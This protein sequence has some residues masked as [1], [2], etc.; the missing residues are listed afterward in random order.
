MVGKARGGMV[1][2]AFITGLFGVVVALVHEHTCPFG[3]CRTPAAGAMV[4]SPGSA[5]NSPAPAS[6]LADL[7]GTWD[8]ELVQSNG[9]RWTVEL[10]IDGGGGTATV[11]YPQLSCIG[12]VTLINVGDTAL[13]YHEHIRTGPCTPEGTITLT[14]RADHRLDCYYVPETGSYTGSAV[15]TKTSG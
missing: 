3:P 2:A 9:R 5:A 1:A 4:S 10:H 8:G 12:D 14:R 6:R 15:L 13:T 7:A 11:T